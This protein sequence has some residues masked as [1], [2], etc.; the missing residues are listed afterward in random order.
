[1]MQIF[2]YGVVFSNLRHLQYI[3]NKLYTEIF[4]IIV[5]TKVCNFIMP[6]KVALSCDAIPCS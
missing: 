6:Q 2:L 5:Y 1:M 3:S 4:I